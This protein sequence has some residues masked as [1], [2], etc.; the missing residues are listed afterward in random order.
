MTM[1]LGRKKRTQ[2]GR[3]ANLMD[4]H[5]EAMEA[6]VES[7]PEGM[8]LVMKLREVLQEALEVMRGNGKTNLPDKLTS[9]CQGQTEKP[10]RGRRVYGGVE[11]A[12]SSSCGSCS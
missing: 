2:I 8:R 6:S 4:V 5:L 7:Q 10:S 12:N 9:R 11:V 1:S 3:R